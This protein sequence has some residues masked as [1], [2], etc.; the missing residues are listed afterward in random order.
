MLYIINKMITEDFFQ[1]LIQADD[2]IL[3]VEEG[4]Y[5]LQINLWKDFLKHHRYAV[6]KE[7]FLARGL[8]DIENTTPF[9]NEIEYVE[10][11]ALHEVIGQL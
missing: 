6:L 9:I 7:D 8:N 1:T 5:N 4:V 11:C 10:Y 2:L 3:F